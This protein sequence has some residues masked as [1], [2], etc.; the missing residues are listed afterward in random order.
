MSLN[1][2][3]THTHTQ[4]HAH[5]HTNTHTDTH[6]HTHKLTHTNIHTH[7]CTQDSH[8]CIYVFCI[9]KYICTPSYDKSPYHSQ[10]N[11]LVYTPSTS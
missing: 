8:D 4:T 6:T 7:T 9:I 2:T 10:M 11:K 3:H 1:H 5:T